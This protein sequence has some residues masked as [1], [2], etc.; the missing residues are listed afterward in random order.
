MKIKRIILLLIIC[1]Q[2]IISCNEKNTTCENLAK[3]DVCVIIKNRS[4][5]MI[6][7][8]ELEHERGFKRIININDDENVNIS[9]NSPGENSYTLTA[10]FEDGTKIKS[11][12]A[13]IEGGYKMT[14]IIHSD[15]IETK[16]LDLY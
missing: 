9:F 1:F 10:T 11:T 16:I 2:L 14:E 5:K 12:G 6:E 15:K 7:S 3:G 8:L 4:G 13:Y